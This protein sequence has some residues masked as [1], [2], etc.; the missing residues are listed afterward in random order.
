MRDAKKYL[1]R[2]VEQHLAKSPEYVFLVDYTKLNVPETK[3]LRAELTKHKAEFHVV[4]NSVLN[5]V[6]KEKGLPDM[7]EHLTGQVAIVVGGTNPAGVAKALK[8]FGKS[9]EKLSIKVGVMSLKKVTSEEIY[10][11]ADLP[12]LEVLRAQLLGLFKEAAASFVR[13]LDAQVKKAAGAP[14][15]A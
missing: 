4:K 15:A 2:E 13:V 3:E 5:V 1:A 9:K 14:A 12:P 6:A 10:F 8:E 11:L 7:S